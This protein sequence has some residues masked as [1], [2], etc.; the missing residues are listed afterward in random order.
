MQQLD[1]SE[2]APKFP[3]AECSSAE[4][5]GAER[6]HSVEG[7]G[8]LQLLLQSAF[9]EIDIFILTETWAVKVFELENF[10]GAHWLAQK[11][12][13]PLAACPYFSEDGLV[14]HP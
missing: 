10:N 6:S 14:I 9:E 5:S 12:V 1:S 7:A 3:G 11:P 13:S 8:A 4:F 2:L